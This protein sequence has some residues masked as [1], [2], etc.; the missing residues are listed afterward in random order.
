MRHLRQ[1][2]DWISGS[3]LR[4]ATASLALAGLLLPGPIAARSPHPQTFT[5]LHSFTGG[6]K[7]G[8]YPYAGLISDGVGNLYG[9]TEFGGS[10]SH[11]LV[12]TIST[13]GKETVLYSF[14]GAADGAYP[15]AGLARDGS[16]NLYGTTAY[17]GSSGNGVVFK[18]SKSGAESVLYSFAGGTA[19]GCNPYGA[20]I[21]DNAG[22]LYGTTEFC[23]ASGY[24]TVFKL[25]AKG[26]ETVLHSFAGGAT[27]GAYPLWTSLRMDKSGNLYGVTDEGGASNVGV[28]YELTSSGAMTVLHNFA[29]GTADGCNPFGAPVM[30]AAGNLYGT[31]EL[32]GS[33]NKGIV[34]KLSS[35]GTETVLQ[36]LTGE[37]G[38]G[39]YPSAGA[40][41]DTQGNLYGDTEGGGPTSNGTVYELSQNGTLTV[42]HAFIGPDGQ[43]PIGGVSRDLKGN[44]YGTTF[45]GGKLGYGTVWKV[46]P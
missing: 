1:N 27:E 15:F 7:D 28:V 21:R 32:C 39:A 5:L 38:S 8:A 40:V 2:R 4:A 9:T 30:D 11:G 20:V 12:F 17:G 23:G 34:W 18:V 6:P 35:D 14:K 3:L 10:S 13:S 16:G 37:T 41:L 24:G 45:S 22:N 46:A 36:N 43:W 31:A 29:G 26:S 42:L 25:D 33:V 44:L 19:D